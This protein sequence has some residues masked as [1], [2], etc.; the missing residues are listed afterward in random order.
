MIKAN[1]LVY[2]ACV[3]KHRSFSVAAKEVRVSKSTLSR[4]VIDLEQGFEHHFS[5]ERAGAWMSRPRASG[6]THAASPCTTPYWRRK[7][8][9]KIS[10]RSAISLQPL[11][12]KPVQLTNK[13]DDRY[14]RRTTFE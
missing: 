13:A 7:K 14:P 2:F 12:G 3:V 6:Y 10:R 11:T 5:R 9:S 4:A 1:H 8:P